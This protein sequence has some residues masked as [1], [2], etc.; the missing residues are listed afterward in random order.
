MSRFTDIDESV[1][2][3]FI[4]VLEERFPSLGQLKIKLIFDTKRRV[5]QG[6]ICLASAELANEKIK[7]FS[8]DDLAIDG[9]DVVITI[10]MKAWEIASKEDR[11]RIMSHELRHVLIDGDDKVKIIPHDVSDFRIEQKLNQENPDWSFKLA[12]LVNDIY[13]QEKEMAKQSKQPKKGD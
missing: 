6:E 7:F 1:I 5:K 8:K 11:K 9:Y 10:D 13:D 12:T 3:T 4:A 2:E